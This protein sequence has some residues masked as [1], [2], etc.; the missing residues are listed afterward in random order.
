[1]SKKK[2]YNEYPIRECRSL[3]YCEICNKDITYGECYYDGG[4]NNRVHVDCFKIYQHEKKI[5]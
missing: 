3:H 2:Q 1:M 4:Y 5:K